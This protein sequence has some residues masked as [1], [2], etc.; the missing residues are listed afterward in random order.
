MP[1]IIEHGV[2]GLL[3]EPGDVRMLAAYLARFALDA[4]YRH[5][6]GEAL[7]RRGKADFSEEATGLRQLE[8]YNAVFRM[9]RNRRDGARDGVLICGAYGFGNTGDDAI[10]QAIIGEMRRIDAH[11]PVTVLSRR[12]KDTQRAFGVNAC[13]RFH[14]VPAHAAP[15]P[16]VHQRRRQPH[17]G[18]YEPPEPVVLSQHDPHGARLRLQG[19]RWPR[20]GIGP[21]VYERDRQLAARII[22]DCVDKITLREPD[23]RETLREFGVTVPEVILASDP[24]LT[25]PAA[26]RSA[27]S[28]AS[29]VSMIWT[30]EGRIG[31]VLR[32]WPGMEEK[33]HR[34]L[35]PALCTPT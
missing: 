21:I 19:C 11:M 28:T 9:E 16:A 8:I 22:N 15:Q 6:M 2:T 12:P 5:E 33:G 32:K 3:I 24:A 31:F 20:H 29:C 1:A 14:Y 35:P 30:S 26:E 34:V 17:A 7:Y 18:C 23:S 25:L 10:L 4:D 27:A 13:N